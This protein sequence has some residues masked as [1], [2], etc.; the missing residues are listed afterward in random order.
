MTGSAFAGAS[1]R[2]RFVSMFSALFAV[3]VAS[4]VL[5][6]WTLHVESLKRVLPG[7][8][9]MNPLTAVCF[10]LAGTS[11]WRLSNGGFSR[12]VPQL[13]GRSRHRIVINLRKRLIVR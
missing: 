3:M 7:L 2:L 12:F 8:V 11:L 9:G 13:L 4:L 1:R 6:G 10:I 5:V